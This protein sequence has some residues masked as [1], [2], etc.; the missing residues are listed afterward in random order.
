MIENFCVMKDVKGKVIVYFYFNEDLVQIINYGLLYDYLIVCQVCLEG[1]CLLINV[2]WEKLF[3]FGEDNIVLL[4]KD[5]DYWFGD[6]SINSIGFFVWFI[7]YGNSGEFDNKFGEKILFMFKIKDNEYDIWIYI[8]EKGKS[9]IWKVLQYLIY[10][11]LVCCVKGQG[12]W[13]IW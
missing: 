5:I 9:L 1:W 4:W 11:F 3:I 12:E 8:F 7:G 13:C 10:G 6:G 2:D